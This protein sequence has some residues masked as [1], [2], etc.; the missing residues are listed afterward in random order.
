V[1][2]FAFSIL[3]PDALDPEPRPTG[4]AGGPVDSALG[5]GPTPVPALAVLGQPAPTRPVP[6]I[7]GWLRWLD[8][9]TGALMGDAEPPDVG[10]PSLTFVDTAG[11]AIQ[12]C[13]PPA[14]YGPDLAVEVRLCPFRD[15]GTARDQITVATFHTPLFFPAFDRRVG[16]VPLQLDATISRDGKWLW[17]ASADL[18]N[19]HTWVVEVRRVDL[20]NGAE[21]VT[22]RIR[23]IPVREFGLQRPSPD[24]WIVESGWILRPVIRASPD[25]TKLSLTVTATDPTAATALLHQERVVFPSSLDPLAAIEIA[26]PVDRPSDLACDPSRAGW[27][28]QRQYLTLCSHRESDGSLQ[29]F[30]R[31]ESAD[32]VTHDV[33]MG[34]AIPD[35]AASF[36]DS[37]WILNARTGRLYR[38]APD[39]LQLSTLDVVSRAG[40]TV[41]LAPDIEPGAGG[42]ETLPGGVTADGRLDW[43]QLAPAG[44]SAAG[45]QLAG[46]GDGRYLYVTARPT[47]AGV[48]GRPVV[49]PRSV[50][51]VIE[52]ATN[53][54]LGRADAPAEID[55]IALAPGGG[56]LLQMLTPVLRDG[57]GLTTDW[58]APVW[59]V[60]PTSGKTLEVVGQVRGPGALPGALVEPLVG[61]L[62]GF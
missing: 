12:V 46:S 44:S 48:G 40:T 4:L 57:S 42:I 26:F 52:A 53:R 33:S 20:A 62:A 6:M 19:D 58:A 17:L 34:T 22:R 45:L 56:P 23:E 2:G 55:Q 11:E 21:I 60:D 18:V 8:P 25:G 43:T 50:V 3:K 39:T 5:Q 9:R 31:I 15:H 38:W 1:A 10:A 16:I 49:S 13:V 37:S 29:P 51:W 41:I 59:F 30:T 61:T 7:A 35:S 24:G 54:L 27:A 32:E 14:Q 47:A 28:G 36:D